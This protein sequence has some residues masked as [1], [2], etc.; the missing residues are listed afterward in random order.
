MCRVNR[1]WRRVPERVGARDNLIFNQ[2]TSSVT[3]DPPNPGR[4]YGGEGGGEVSGEVGGGGGG[5]GGDEGGDEVGGELLFR[6]S[7]V[8]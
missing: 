7:D 4:R 5:E 3:Q 1:G 6:L 8:L 2:L